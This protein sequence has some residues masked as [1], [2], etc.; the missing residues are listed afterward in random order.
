[1]LDCKKFYNLLVDREIEFFTGIPDSLLKDFNAYIIDNV[2]N[3]KH[4]IAANEGA[5]IALAAGHY[6]ATKKMV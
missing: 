5:S 4:I 1:M 6:L 3:D 2:K